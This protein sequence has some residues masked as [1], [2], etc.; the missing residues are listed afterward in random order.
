MSAL[1]VTGLPLKEQRIVVFGPGAAGIGN[2]DQIAEA[3]LLDGLSKKEAYDRFWAVDYRGLLTDEVPDTLK[4]QKPYTRKAE[5]VN[6]WER[7]EDG[8]ISLMEVVKR[9]KPTILIGTSG[10]AGAF[11]EEIV[12][13]MAKHVSR[14]IIMPMSNPTA[15]AEA[16]PVDLMNWTE[17]QV[18]IATGS[19]FENVL[20]NGISYE[21]G[22]SNNAFV[23]PGL[24]LGAIVARAEIISKG[25]FA[26]A[27][28][29]VAKMSS[30]NM[31]G[32]PLLPS[33]NK[34][35][36]VSEYV[37]IEVAKAAIS[38]GIAKANI[39]DIEKAVANAMWKPEYK[40]VKSFAV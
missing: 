38:E 28:N 11:S 7:N 6:G 35:H 37:A 5:E 16:V 31:P 22:Q 20:Y 40:E 14:P 18:L 30:S 8:I 39:N 26:A 33:I 3:M 27:A 24:G 36:E 10:Q 25:M 17:G 23:F 21:I 13:E 1:K 2:A 34:L 15:L 29:A 32:A 4:F 12:K 9:V 19:P